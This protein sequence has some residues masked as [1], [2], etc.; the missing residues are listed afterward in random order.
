MKHEPSRR[1]FLIRLAETEELCC[2]VRG[3]AGEEGASAEVGM[4]AVRALMAAHE[5]AAGE[6]LGRKAFRFL[7]PAGAERLMVAAALKVRGDAARP[8]Q[9]AASDR[10]SAADA[11]TGPA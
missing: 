2:A 3:L 4:E 11:V 10:P 5:E 6:R 1:H 9:P 7:A 8:F